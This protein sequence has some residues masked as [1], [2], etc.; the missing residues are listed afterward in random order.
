VVSF[1][2]EREEAR[3]YIDELR[4]RATSPDVEVET[5]SGGNQQKVVLAR[6]S[7]SRARV[8]ILDDPTRGIDVGA[9]E[10]VFALVRRLAGNGAGILFLTS[11]IREAKALAD[12]VLVMADG[13]IVDSVDPR[14][15]EEEIMAMAG[16]ARV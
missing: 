7:C 1:G 5:L 16:G 13:A 11:E 15:S 4:I 12:R 8:L 6:W 2:A 10:E 14:T 9:K 3:R